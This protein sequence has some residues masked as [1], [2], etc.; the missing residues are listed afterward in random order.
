MVFAGDYKLRFKA[1]ILENFRRKKDKMESVKFDYT[2][3][4][5][6]VFSAFA[7]DR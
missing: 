2:G 1:E 6:P 7:N 5:C 4:M 3:L